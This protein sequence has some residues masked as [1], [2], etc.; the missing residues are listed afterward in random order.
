VWINTDAGYSATVRMAPVGRR[1]RCAWSDGTVVL[2][3]CIRRMPIFGG[4]VGMGAVRGNGGAMPPTLE[5]AVAAARAR[6][7]AWE[8]DSDR[9]LLAVRTEGGD[10]YTTDIL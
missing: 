1:L 10:G 6:W 5:E 7:G 8:H 9:M 4:Y 3:G 2:S